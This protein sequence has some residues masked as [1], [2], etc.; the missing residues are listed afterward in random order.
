MADKESIWQAESKQFT[1]DDE[2]WR[3]VVERDPAADG[4]FVYSVQSTGVYCRP[5][6]PARLALRKNVA[7]HD[8]CEA[9]E[10]AGFRACRRCSP[11]AASL[12]TQHSEIVAK[13]CRLVEEAEEALNLD[14]L[15]AAVGMSPYH[16]HRIFKVHTGVTPSAYAR[17][18]RKS[19]VVQELSAS[20]TITGAIY[21]AGYSS[22]SR[23]YE[24]SNAS[25]G[26]TPTMFRESGRGAVI[27]F[28]VGECYLG[29]ILVAVSEKGVCEISLGDDPEKLIHELQDHFANAKLIGADPGFEELV[30]KVVGFVSDPATGLDL[31]LD[32]RGTAFQMK[33]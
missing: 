3:A 22:S 27:W 4:R 2:R 29:A 7:F 20:N 24:S 30:S 14:E 13:A 18:H 12:R 31:P 16:F 19:R 6:C 1:T 11:N 8:S 15:A 33:V 5:V 21:D 23:F 10:R 28:A 26:M 17:A 32:I 25:L 9:A